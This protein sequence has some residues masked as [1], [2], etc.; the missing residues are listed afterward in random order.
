MN[1]LHLFLNGYQYK[2][3]IWIVNIFLWVYLFPNATSV[4]VSSALSCPLLLW[5]AL[6][7]QNIS[8]EFFLNISSTTQQKSVVY[9]YPLQ[10]YVYCY[11]TAQCNLIER[12]VQLEPISECSW[13][14]VLQ[15][16]E[17]ITTGVWLMYICKEFLVMQPKLLY[18]SFVIQHE[19]TAS[20]SFFNSPK[21]WKSQV[22]S[23]GRVQNYGAPSITWHSVGPKFRG[24]HGDGHCCVAE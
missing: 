22:I 13:V 18:H 7:T 2:G 20:E 15:Q 19:H 4:C 14:E 10:W 23:M 3:F 16:L 17:K 6:H 24:P 1:L 21:T 9:K 8:N 12:H 5:K 11:F